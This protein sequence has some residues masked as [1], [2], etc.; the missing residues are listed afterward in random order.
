MSNSNEYKHGY[1]DAIQFAISEINESVDNF[2]IGENE[3]D[4]II[5]SLKT[6]FRKV[7]QDG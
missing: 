5:N 6:I 4:R 7:C 1:R 3:A 2:R